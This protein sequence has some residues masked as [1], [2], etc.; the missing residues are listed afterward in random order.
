MNKLLIR[1]G[2]LALALIASPSPAQTGT[3][4]QFP[5]GWAPSTSICVKQ[6][7]GTCAPVST[8]NPLPVTGGT[9]GGG[10]GGDPSSTGIVSST[11]A[12]ATVSMGGLYDG[13][14]IRRA[15]GDSS[16]RA[17]VNVSSLPA[18]PSGANTIGSVNV[19]GFRYQLLGSYAGAA[20]TAN[21]TGAAVGPVQPNA[22]IFSCSGTIGGGTITLQVLGPDGTT[23]QTVSGVSFTSLPASA[24]VVMPNVVGASGSGSV[25]T[26]NARAVLTGATSPAVYCS[27]S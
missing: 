2:A 7:D 22:Y 9:G 1:A 16:G 27:L 11:T 8:T 25:S 10:G 14:T 17:F 21:G 24:G 3:S 6:V 13:T 5:G 4:V 20:Q 12:P 26:A 18:L 23:F 19:I 15:L